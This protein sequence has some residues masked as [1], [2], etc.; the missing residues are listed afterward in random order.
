[1]IG[2]SPLTSTVGTSAI[3]QV[4]SDEFR[5]LDVSVRETDYVAGREN[6]T[7]IVI[8]NTYPVPIELQSVVARNSILTSG[9]K[10]A[11]FDGRAP[12]RLRPSKTGFRFR[13]P[14]FFSVGSSKPLF[15]FTHQ[16]ET[17]SAAEPI[18]VDAANGAVVSIDAS[19]TVDREIQISADQGAHINIVESQSPKVDPDK[20]A[21]ITPMSEIVAEYI[22]N[23]THALLFIPSRI[24]IDIEIKYRISEEERSQVVSATLDIKPPISSVIFG[25]VFGGLIGSLAKSLTSANEFSLDWRLVV[26]MAGSALLAVMATIAL[27][28]KSGTQAFITVEDFFGA[29]VLGSLIGY[30]GASFFEKTV[31]GLHPPPSS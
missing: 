1:M 24:G 8:R 19:A 3:E 17:L 6:I 21:I 5:K 4:N 27:S 31:S 26:Q 9:S 29:F 2:I 25:S 7:V 30:Q 11:A 14:N 12:R 22:W 13:L 23:T 16:M 18:K 20:S 28:R 15:E 10:I